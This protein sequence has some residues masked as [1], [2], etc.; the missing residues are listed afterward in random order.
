MT[1]TADLLPE[2]LATAIET[3]TGARITAGVLTIL[4][5]GANVLRACGGVALVGAVQ[6]YAAVGAAGSMMGTVFGALLSIAWSS[7]MLWALFSSRSAQICTPR[8]RE[9]M[10]RTAHL[11][12]R[13]F[14]SPFFWVPFIGIALMVMLAVA[15]AALFVSMRSGLQ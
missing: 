14:A 7:A 15:G 2:G 13:T 3:E 9:V 5:L 11:R 12:P 4:G 1:A 10:A 6:T 8:Y